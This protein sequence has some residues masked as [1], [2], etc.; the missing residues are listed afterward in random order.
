MVGVKS[1]SAE[2]GRH[3]LSH[4][5]KQPLLSVAFVRIVPE[6]LTCVQSLPSHTPGRPDSPFSP[7]TDGD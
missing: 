3:G 2:G 5:Y 7:F 6:H 1:T 4:G